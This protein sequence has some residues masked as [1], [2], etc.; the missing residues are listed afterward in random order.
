MSIQAVIDYFAEAGVPADDAERATAAAGSTGFS[1]TSAE[2]RSVLEVRQLIG[3]VYADGG[4]LRNS[5]GAGGVTS[6]KL[7]E[8][9]KISGSAAD[10][11]AIE[12]VLTALQHGR[13]LDDDE[14]D[15]VSG[16]TRAMVLPEVDDEVLVAFASGDA[17]RPYAIGFLWNGK[18]KPPA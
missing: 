9:A 8:L 5:W 3:T 1:F 15:R 7:A 13:E 12:A 17:R 10:P 16:G 14:L 6:A 18:D 2:L 11:K 4:R